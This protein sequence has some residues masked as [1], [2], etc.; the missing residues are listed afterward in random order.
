MTDTQPLEA[1]LEAVDEA[2]PGLRGRIA[3]A[4]SELYAVGGRSADAIGMAHNG[5]RLG[6]QIG[7]LQLCARAS[8][9]AALAEA[10]DLQPQAATEHYRQARTY[11]QQA[12]DL[13]REGWIVPRMAVALLM[14]GRFDE[15]RIL[16][17]E[18]YDLVEKTN[19]W[20]NHALTLSS[21]VGMEVATGAFD[22]AERLAQEAL[23]LVMRYRTPYTGLFIPSD[24]ACAHALRGNWSAA[25]AALDT[26]HDSVFERIDPS[27]H[28]CV[29]VYRQLMRTYD[30]DRVSLETS[31]MSW[32]DIP[33]PE[34]CN[35]QSLP[36]CCALVE[37]SAAY[38][39][40]DLASHLYRLIESVEA[41]GVLFTRGW[42]FFT[43]RILGL[44]AAL[45]QRWDRAE[46][47]FQAALA[48]ATEIGAVS[49][50]GR[51]YLDYAQMLMARGAQEDYRQALERV[52]KA[53]VLF[54]QLGMAPFARR[55]DQ[56]TDVLQSNLK[57][58]Q[59]FEFLNKNDL[60]DYELDTLVRMCQIGLSILRC[61][62]Y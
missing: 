56:L 47:H 26:M 46:A 7:D 3:V 38:Q 19:N 15:L 31:A 11:A 55:A 28:L 35:Y 36:L 10:Q 33:P 4:L 25:A 60:S 42:S 51:V 57:P 14:L 17:D 30:P 12:K 21:L 61:K 5:L 24:L 50:Q 18:T 53:A 16:A 6:Q 20:K 43:P 9:N 58:Q 27:F 29:E 59:T 37:L 62:L 52:Q 40:P 45:D 34:T 1:C 22:R 54:H 49:Q 23:G 44:A 41:Q 39:E 8:F 48:I 13:Y 2:L 32:R